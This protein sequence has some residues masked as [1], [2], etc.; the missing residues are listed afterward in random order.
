MAVKCPV[1]GGADTAAA[2]DNSHCLTCGAIFNAGKK[3]EP[4]LGQSTRDALEAR[5]AP[6]QHNVI[7]NYADVQRL[8]A[9]KAPDPSEPAFAMPAGADASKM[10]GASDDTTTSAA[11]DSAAAAP[12]PV[13]DTA[14]GDTSK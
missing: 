3:V 2:L 14:S 5:L 10:P 12:A 1:C 6:R 8:G 9:Q 13:A 7:G 11:S 4:G